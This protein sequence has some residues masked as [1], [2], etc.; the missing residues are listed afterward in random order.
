[1]T[2]HRARVAAEQ[3]T[4]V[5][6]CNVLTQRASDS[7]FFYPVGGDDDREKRKNNEGGSRKRNLRADE[8]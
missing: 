6:K 7:P 4:I 1:M 3:H 2:R 5:G 8:S